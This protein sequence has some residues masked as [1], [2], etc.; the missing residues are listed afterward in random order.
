MR[1]RQVKHHGL[2]QKQVDLIITIFRPYAEQIE[3]ICLF[4]SRARGT[5]R[6]NSDIDFVIHGSLDEKTAD[7][8]WTLFNESSLPFKVD[9][10]VYDLVTFLPLKAHIDERSVPFLKKSDLMKHTKMPPEANAAIAS[11][12]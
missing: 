10:K 4:G 5:Y 11:S 7:R 2:S 1:D 3:K 9:V 8:L 6:P 12:P